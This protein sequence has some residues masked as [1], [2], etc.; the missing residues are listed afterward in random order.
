MNFSHVPSGGTLRS[1]VG[2]FVGASGIVPLVAQSSSSTGGGTYSSDLSLPAMPPASRPWELP[3]YFPPPPPLLGAPVPLPK[4]AIS[5]RSTPAPPELVEYVNEIF[6]APLST[7]LDKKQLTPR[8]REKL[9]AYRAAKVALQDELQDRLASLPSADPSARTQ[10]LA[11]FARAQAPR[12]AQL[13]HAAEELRRDLIHGEFLQ[14]NVDWNAIRGWRLGSSQFSASN[15]AMNAQYQVMLAAA[16]YQN[17]L[18]PEQRGLLREIALELQTVPRRVSDEEAGGLINPPLFFSP[19]TSRLLLPAGVP[20]EVGE[21]IAAY[22]KEKSAIKRELRD[23]VYAQDKTF[24]NRTRN[25]VLEALAERQ[26]PQIAAL[27]ELAEDIRRDLARLPN[28]PGPPPAPPLPAALTAHIMEFLAERNELR[29][30][31]VRKVEELK[32]RFPFIR[33]QST[34]NASGTSDLKL[35][36]SPRP[37]NDEEMK[38]LRT[39]LTAFNQEIAT[40]QGQL[41]KSEQAIR[42]EF[43]ITA[44]PGEG[45]SAEG[46]LDDYAEI[47][48][49]R[50][51]WSLYGAYQTAMLTPGLSPEQRRLLF[52]RGLEKLSLPLPNWDQILI[53]VVN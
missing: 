51:D 9:Q 15:D 36:I 18:L 10:E 19:A 29:T 44:A 4:V 7:R 20:S 48:Q 12:I 16:F 28:Q 49:Q 46:L 34:R 43:E 52:D 50:E 22:E 45:H 32:K 24:F 41:R 35:L 47:L 26:W 53:R 11:E 23:T 3:I 21:K 38:A 39:T 17:G 1:L 27:E 31:I 13:E 37:D 8:Q 40:R 33:I 30:E 42:R 6:Y 14:A 25:R 2:F 5:R